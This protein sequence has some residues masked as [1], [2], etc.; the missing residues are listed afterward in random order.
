[1]R[2]QLYQQ[3]A[4]K[5]LSLGDLPRAR[6]ILTDHLTNPMQRQQAL[7]NLEQQSIQMIA[8][9]GRI[10]EALR[11]V[12]SLRTPRERAT[13]LS[14][15][16]TQIGPEQKRAAALDLLEQARSLLGTA[17]RVE[18]QE[19]MTALLEIAAAFSR[20]DSKRAFEVVE[21]LLD[22]FNEMSAAALV[23]NGFGQEFYEDG[24]LAM[25]N[26]NSVANIGNQLIASLSMLATSNFDRARAG[27]DRLERPEVR[28]SAYLAIAKQTIGRDAQRRNQEYR[29][30][31]RK[32]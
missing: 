19:Q 12:G 26:G 27:A 15:V 17:T 32:W 20:Y 6:Q 29:R 30:F 4:Q 16:I 2:D 25:Q 28:L 31:Q 7:S 23:L 1:M 8:S 21:P 9:K 24:E 10:D 11:L 13:M 3:V 22:Q 5:A 14:Q 18:S